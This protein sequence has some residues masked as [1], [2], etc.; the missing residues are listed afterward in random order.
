MKKAKVN[1]KDLKLLGISHPEMLIA[2]GREANRILKR[3]TLCKVDILNAIG[4]MMANTDSKRW[5]NHPLQEISK[6]ITTSFAEKDTRIPAQSDKTNA[7]LRDVPLVYPTYGAHQI[8]AG[9]ILQMDRAMSL[10]ISLAGALMPDAHEGYGLP[11]GGVLA[12][13]EGVVIPYAVGVDIACRM[14]MSVFPMQPNQLDKVRVK[15]RNLLGKYTIFGV[16]SKNK[17]HIDSS[18]FDKNEW[19]AT[20]FIR[21]HRDLAFSQLGTSGAGNHFVEWGELRVLTD[22]PEVNLKKGNYIALLSHSGSRG[23]GNEVAN[24]YSKVAMQ[25]VNLPRE[26]RHL[27]WLDLSSEEGHEYWI[28]MNLAGEYASAN[29]REIHNKIQRDVG[30]IPITRIENH[31]NFAWKEKLP[32]GRYSVIHR[33]GATP[34]SKGTVGII[35]GSMTHPGYIVRGK[36]NPESLNSASHGAGRRMSRSQAMKLIE[37]SEME[38]VLEKHGVELIG[39]DLD[40]APMAYKNIEEVMDLQKDL[41]EVLAIFQPRIV[42]MAEGKRK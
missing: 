1:N 6:L 22:A 16:G 24:H 37:W 12:T 19:K 18:L 30:L 29:H 38:K 23:F 21:Q 40:E 28:A 10:P 5:E 26:A 31:H 36:G 13:N 7:I 9:A 39:G 33:K 3:R 4:E 17:D 34:A 11:I 2:I 35:P 8:E 41:V 25:R 42:R 32:D 20:R 14:C 27:A 15:L